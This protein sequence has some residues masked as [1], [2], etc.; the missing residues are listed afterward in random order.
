MLNI[1]IAII[2]NFDKTYIDLIKQQSDYEVELYS[3]GDISTK[4]AEILVGIGFINEY[5]ASSIMNSK[6]IK[7]IHIL[8]A[9][10]EN[11]PFKEIKQKNIIVTNSTGIHGIPISEHVFGMLLNFTRN[12]FMF[13]EQKKQKIWKQQIGTELCGKTMGIVGLGSIG[14]EIA[15]KAK[16]FDMKVIGI[17]KNKVP[18]ENVDCVYASE[19][20]QE[21]LLQSDF[22]V[23]ALPSTP[24]TK[25]LISKK[26]FESM[27]DGA[28]FVNISRGQIVDEASLI[29]ALKNGK[30][31]GA[32]LDVFEE[33]PLSLDSEI[34]DI[35]NVIISPHLA[36]LSPAYFDRAFKLFLYNLKQFEDKKELKNIIDLD[37]EY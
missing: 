37:M 11:L 19:E 5:T 34:W 14:C 24:L 8:A 16:A 20:L 17:K 9:G 25:K 13:Q 36:S 30:L 7:W 1:K 4:D 35:G 29:E 10:V 33:E 32:C 23:I 6:K 12:L 31:K 3:K 18:L 28:Y 27:K 15:R 2:G 22:V 21:V 26:E